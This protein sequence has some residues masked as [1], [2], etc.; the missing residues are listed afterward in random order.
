VLPRCV[1]IIETHLRLQSKAIFVIEEDSI[2]PSNWNPSAEIELLLDAQRNA[3]QSA[4]GS[5]RPTPQ[6][7]DV[8]LSGVKWTFGSEDGLDAMLVVL[9]SFSEVWSSQLLFDVAPVTE[10]ERLASEWSLI[11]E[12]ADSGLGL[13]LVL[14]VD[15]QSTTTSS[16]LMRRYGTLSDLARIDLDNLLRAYAMGDA[17]SIEL[18]ASRQ[19]RLSIRYH[20]EWDEF[21]KQLIALSKAFSTSLRVERRGKES[22]DEERKAL[23]L[24]DRAMVHGRETSS[25]E[26]TAC[27]WEYLNRAPFIQ[28]KQLFRGSTPRFLG[29]AIALLYSADNQTEYVYRSAPSRLNQDSFQRLEPLL[30]LRLSNLLAASDVHAIL[31]ELTGAALHP[32]LTSTE[33]AIVVESI[34]LVKK[35]QTTAGVS[36]LRLAARRHSS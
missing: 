28:C 21:L 18:K 11:L 15:I 4:F 12:P 19:G 6:V 22:V 16:M 13:P 36:T 20:P 23:A 10:D 32:G 3:L 9:R 33:L 7:G 5:D 14:H 26:D 2:M 35:Y 29:E 8:W 24:S 31:H 1:S 30:D 25:D 27:S 34:R 17:S